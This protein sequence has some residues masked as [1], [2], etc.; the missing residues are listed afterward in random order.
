MATPTMLV[1]RV[2]MMMMMMFCVYNRLWQLIVSRE[3]QL[4]NLQRQQQQ[5]QLLLQQLQALLETAETRQVIAHVAPSVT[6]LV[7]R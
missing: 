7:A 6:P 3:L 4:R 5:T 2:L 1:A